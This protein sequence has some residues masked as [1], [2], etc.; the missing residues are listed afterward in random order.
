MNQPQIQMQDTGDYLAQLLLKHELIDEKQLQHAQRVRSKLA[1]PKTLLNTMLSLDYFTQKQF[2]AALS[3]GDHN[4]RLG[5]LLVEMGELTLQELETA[6]RLQRT[7]AEAGRMRRLGQVLVDLR[8]IREQ[9]LIEVLSNLLGLPHAEPDFA[10]IERKVLIGATPD[11]CERHQFIPLRKEGDH[12]LVA[13]TDPSN[14]EIRRIAEILLNAKVKLAISSE[15]ALK[16][17]ISKFK[18]SLDGLQ[19]DTTVEDSKVVRM[20]D[21]VLQAA[22]ALNTSDIH[23]EPWSDKL[24]VRFRRD[25]V[26]WPY[27][28]LPI[29][30]APSFLS[31]LKILAKAN[32][33]ERRRHQD[34]KI[35]FN[36]PQSGQT[37]DVRCSFYVSVHGEKACLRLLNRKAV[38]LNIEEIGMAPAVLERFKYDA[39]DVASGVLLVTGPTGSGKTT[40]LYGCVDYLK[41]EE[42]SIIT[43][44]EPVEYVIE[45]ITQCSLNPKIDM[46]FAESLRHMVRQDPDV[47]VLGEVRDSE[48]AESAIQAAMTGHKVLTTFHT[49]D[50]IGALLRLMN[51]NIETFL[52]ASTVVA[53]LAQRLLRRVCPHCAQPYRPSAQEM[54][55]VGLRPDELRLTD[56]KVGSGCE[57]CHYSGYQGRVSVFELLILNEHVKDAVLSR[58]ASYDIRRIALETTSLV[59]LFEDGLEKAA[60]GITTLNEILRTLPRTERPRSL[61][62]IRRLSGYTHG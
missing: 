52:I 29:D 15:N 12:V 48:S 18:A 34:G 40:T 46:T 43:A 21:E 58:K 41:D 61:T 26:L 25:G 38:L 51:M 57:A 45:G 14:G 53:V 39:L 27:K 3:Q 9:R 44:E 60:R 37:I 19:R 31:R 24:S 4:V 35:E 22:I 17:A 47:I 5:D 55:R 2:N 8:F 1:N 13:C 23:I 59:T 30:V 54:Q 28:D 6:L 49:E 42:T 7:A 16:V 56:L 20:V 33:A 10:K 11:W 50:T 36:D 32:I 62:D